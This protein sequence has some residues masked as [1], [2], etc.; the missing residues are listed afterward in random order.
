VHFYPSDEHLGDCAATVRNAVCL[1]MCLL[2]A[3]C[4]IPQQMCTAFRSTSPGCLRSQ[5]G[6]RR[7]KIRER[8]Q[9]P[10]MR[11]PLQLT[12][13]YAAHTC[14]HLIA[15]TLTHTH[16]HARTH[17]HTHTHTRTHTRTHHVNI[18]LQLHCG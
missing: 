7:R 15:R 17:T 3:S 13:R 9:T 1:A 4:Y 11:T 5:R 18:T 12:Q 6:R 2:Q 14:S 10:R 16:T 8:G